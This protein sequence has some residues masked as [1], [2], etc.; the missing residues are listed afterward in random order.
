MI[1]IL[2]L[3]IISILPFSYADKPWLPAL[4]PEPY[5]HPQKAAWYIDYEG[6]NDA[7]D[8]KTPG[9][10]FKH[11]PG[12][13]N[14]KDVAQ[15][16]ELSPGDVVL[17]KGGVEYRGT[18]NIRQ[19][20]TSDAPIIL[21]GNTAGVFGKGPAILEGG[22]L[23]PS[24]RPASSLEE[25]G[26]NTRWSE[27]LVADL[28][29]TY[30]WKTINLASTT[31]VFPVAQ[32]PNPSDTIFQENTADYYQVDRQIQHSSP[33]S[34]SLEAGTKGNR[35][36]PLL[37][38]LP[39][40][41]GSAVVSPVVGAA[42]SVGL[43][44]PQP[45]IQLGIMMQ[46]KYTPVKEMVFEAD[47]KEVLRVEL[48]ADENKLQMFALPEALEFKKLT[49]RFLSVHGEIKND[50]TAIAQIAAVTAEGENIFDVKL[51]SM[52]VDPVNLTSRNPEAYQG[53]TVG[54][55]AGPN[56]L[57]YEEVTGF[58]PSTGTLHMPFFGQKLYKETKYSLF[59]G[60][61]LIDQPAEYA[62][63]PGPEGKGTRV[64][65]LPPENVDLQ[66]VTFSPGRGGIETENA[67]HLR[68]QGFIIRRQG[69]KSAIRLR[70]TRDVKIR[71]C[72]VHF[73][74]A[75]SAVYAGTSDRVMFDGGQVREC[76]GHTKGLVFQKSQNV[77][78][79][80]SRF[81]RNTSTGV[82]YYT[83]TD[84]DMTGNYVTDHKGMHANGLTLYL[85]CKNIVVEKNVVTGGNAALTFQQADNLT[86]TRNVFDGDGN[87]MSVG[88]WNASPL[89]NIKFIRNTIVG[90]NPDSDWQVGVFTNNK[91]IRN[92][93]F[94]GN[95]IDG[96]SG[97]FGDGTRV[98]NL[99][100]R[101]S[102]GQTLE[103]DGHILGKDKLPTLFMDAAADDYRLREDSKFKGLGA[104]GE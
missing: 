102:S 24:W 46:P 90:G 84:G 54:F 61:S 32:E 78:V 22:D 21:D 41:R 15:S 10:A 62:I 104:Y 18:L 75:G 43:Q 60:V 96:M 28:P 53:L 68:F 31:R 45:V 82:D 33:L 59:N 76:P 12:D 44:V 50:W 16:T 79:R 103:A 94:E 99:Y 38:A 13:P 7:A 86:F 5:E 74:R 51:S 83:C 35:Q 2:C 67:K 4:S 14:A 89:T 52:I 69:G 98:N 100:L 88:I 40:E 6:G 11:C 87:S 81:D 36:R 19:S 73:V 48:K 47:G 57:F 17:F 20:G 55:H 58:D 25:A 70:S 30:S 85:S 66:K 64:F 27:I 65:F 9:T 91:S 29:G 34:L 42:F 3:L 92:M 95:I 23:V 80:N 56:A 37:L 93:S 72:D 1:S 8:G 97:N 77:S 39:S 63:Q 71:D 49:Y 26:G 101:P